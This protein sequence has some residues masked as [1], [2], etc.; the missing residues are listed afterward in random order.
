MRE[1]T[2]EKPFGFDD[3][4]DKNK[5]FEDANRRIEETIEKWKSEYPSVNINELFATVSLEFTN[6]KKTREIFNKII[7]I[8]KYE[9]IQFL[10]IV[11]MVSVLALQKN[12]LP[13]E[14]KQY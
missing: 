2:E 8:K 11:E 4:N 9:E 13:N 10:T 12:Q 1:N 5:H 3:E 14:E 7:E 6:N